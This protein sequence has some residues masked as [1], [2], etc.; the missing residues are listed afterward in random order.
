[1]QYLAW[2]D[3]GDDSYSA[4]LGFDEPYD[5]LLN[6]TLKWVQPNFTIAEILPDFCEGLCRTTVKL[7]VV[8]RAPGH[9]YCKFGLVVVKGWVDDEG[10]AACRV[11]VLSPGALDVRFSK[12][13]RHWFGP[14]QF[15]YG[16]V[17]GGMNSLLM[18]LPAGLCALVVGVAVTYAIAWYAK[19]KMRE[20]RRRHARFLSRR[21]K[22]AE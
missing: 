3:D 12:D 21:A 6:E 2:D 4:G 16:V 19:M 14:V 1:M 15:R 7:R 5:D 8:P 17:T 11:P 18:F 13:K 22:R 10:I 20:D 9:C